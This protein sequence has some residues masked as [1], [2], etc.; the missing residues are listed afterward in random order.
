MSE[1]ALTTPDG[2]V[3]LFGSLDGDVDILLVTGRNLADDFTVDRVDN[4]ESLARLGVYEFTVD[5]ETGREGRLS[6]EFTT[7][8][9]K[10]V[11]KSA[12]H[13]GSRYDVGGVDEFGRP[14]DGDVAGWLVYIQANIRGQ[15]PLASIT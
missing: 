2:L 8:G 12:G 9:G 7:G 13:V 3:S 10:V 4:I 15:F 14:S 5:E 1:D 6:L 11:F